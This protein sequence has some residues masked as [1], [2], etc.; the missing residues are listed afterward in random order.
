MSSSSC[1]CTNNVSSLLVIFSMISVLLILPTG[2][3]LSQSARNA[4][5]QTN[6]ERFEQLRTKQHELLK[7]IMQS[8]SVLAN[9]E[10]N[11]DSELLALDELEKSDERKEQLTK[12]EEEK[13]SNIKS[14][15]AL[16]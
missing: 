9:I 14:L 1:S 15:E 3:F 7:L 13:T 16:H 2:L 8:Q 12:A 10:V 6:E 11:I 4:V 5:Q